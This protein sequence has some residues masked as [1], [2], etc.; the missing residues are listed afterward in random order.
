[1]TMTVRPVRP[2]EFE[3]VGQLTIM[4]YDAVGSIQ[5]SYRDQ[6]VDTAARVADGAD[7]LVAV[8]GEGGDGERGDGDQLLGSV[9]YVDADN[10]HF[11]NQG[12]GDCSFRMLAVDVDAQ[13]RG[14]G[15]ALVQAC[16]DRARERAG[17]RLAIYSMEWMPV[18][19][20]LYASMGFT[21]RPDRDVMFPA[22][23][24]FAFQLDLAED[25]EAHFAPPGPVPA[26][27]PWYEDAWAATAT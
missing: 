13:G 17:R 16:I 15:R 11:E 25:A 5:G 27:P 8:N 9:T 2:H 19:H 1:M 22:G 26:E 23:I 6:L 3:A 21:R 18:A 4:A 7:V 10:P 14:A 20:A 24:G 12:G